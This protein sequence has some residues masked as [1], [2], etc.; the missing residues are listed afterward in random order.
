MAHYG[1][2]IV[3]VS[4]LITSLLIVNQS[5]LSHPLDSYDDEMVVTN[6]TVADT[7]VAGGSIVS[8]LLH[9]FEDSNNSHP[10]KTVDFTFLG[11]PS[12]SEATSFQ[13][14]AIAA[15][16]Y[17][18]RRDSVT[19]ESDLSIFAQGSLTGFYRVGVY[20]HHFAPEDKYRITYAVNFAH[21]PLHFWGLGYD[22]AVDNANESEYTELRT[23]GNVELTWRLAR[24]LYL[25]PTV[26]IGYS[27]ATK[28]ENPALWCGQRMDVFSCGVGAALYFDTRDYPLNAANGWNLI[29]KQ[30]FY[31]GVMGNKNPFILT[32]LTTSWY[33]Q[34]WRTGVLACMFHCGSTYGGTVSW[35]KMPTL[36]QS[37]GVR[38][39][40]DGRYRDK[41]ES[42]VVVELRQH[43]YRRSGI[44]VWCGA[45]S[46]FSRLNEVR[47]KRI[48][49]SGGVGYRWELKE[50]VNIRV[51][52]GV[53]REST[54][55]SFGLNEAF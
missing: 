3:E 1:L 46:V 29:L 35:T 11:G 10:D 27:K 43:I 4:A 30:Q 14:A 9:Y 13:L 39:Y 6:E 54:S 24:K 53:G 32:E 40:Y 8:R 37:G 17:Y 23:L 41:S 36:D 18:A 34:V 5:A 42:D 47:L 44:V 52:F 49:P 19:P 38:S 28:V 16:V 7:V 15:G 21:F 2:K 48:L 50:R 51:D 22:M 45:G 12:Y 25:G 20:G 33:K 55:F 26:D 31:P